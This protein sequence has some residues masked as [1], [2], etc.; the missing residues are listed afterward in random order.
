MIQQ[1]NEDDF[2]N[3]YSLMQK[4][5]PPDEYRTYKEQR[6]LLDD[7]QYC[8]YVLEDS[9]TDKIKAFIAVWTFED[10]AFIEHLAVNPLY[11][12][13][14]IGAAM[15][16]EVVDALACQVCLE[17]ELPETEI[18]KRRIGF[19]ERNGFV[20]NHYPYI[21][22]PIS[23][24]RNPIPLFLMTSERGVEE[25]RFEMIKSVLYKQVYGLL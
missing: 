22:P 4:S 14:G 20:L 17:V 8:I 25:E 9:G 24:G 2:D 19:Y 6:E 15:L 3:I 18:A 5:F 1:L 21:Q 23:K 16:Q 13:G 12:N 11:R 7:P 10:F